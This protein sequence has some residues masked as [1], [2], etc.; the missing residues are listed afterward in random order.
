MYLCQCNKIPERAIRAAIAEIRNRELATPVVPG[1][2][3]VMLN[4]QGK[5][6]G[7]YP[8]IESI[9]AECGLGSEER[10]TNTASNP[11]TVTTGHEDWNASAA[12]TRR[13]GGAFG[14]R[15]GVTGR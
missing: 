11:E 12:P 5:C 4:R 15:A 9:L 6:L 14:R 7:C 8:L 10:S 3:L 2:V 13:R 1:D